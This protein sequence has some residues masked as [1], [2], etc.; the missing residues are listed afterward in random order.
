M[1]LVCYVV[2]VSSEWLLTSLFIADSLELKIFI[3][4]LYLF[5]LT[6]TFITFIVEMIPAFGKNGTFVFPIIF[7]YLY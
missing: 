1:T 5:L 6:R 7:K 4:V 3:I 2:L